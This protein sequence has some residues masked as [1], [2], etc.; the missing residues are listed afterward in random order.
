MKAKLVFLVLYATL[1]TS[2]ECIKVPVETDENSTT[3]VQPPDDVE[4]ESVKNTTEIETE[5]DSKEAR[6]IDD[7][8]DKLPDYPLTTPTDVHKIPPTL[9]N[10]K[11]VEPA[12]KEKP[13]KSL[14]DFA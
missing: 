8:D 5:N 10:V 6:T 13:E 2:V 1:L 11:K 3:T 9:Q 7:K 4:N 14:K 12:V